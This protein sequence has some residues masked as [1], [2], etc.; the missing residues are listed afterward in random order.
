M[1]GIASQTIT[2]EEHSAEDSVGSSPRPKSIELRVTDTGILAMLATL[3]VVAT[4][5]LVFSRARFYIELA[6]QSLYLLMIE[7]P[8]AAIRSASGYHALL[9]PLFDAVGGSVV[10][11]RLLR[12]VLDIGVDI[13]LGFSLIRYL[14]RRHPDGKFDSTAAAG[15]V[16]ST[17]TLVGFSVWT[18]AVNGFGYDQLGGILFTVW[19]ALVLWLVTDDES[20]TNCALLA[21]AIGVVFTLG[22]IVR[23]TAS[24]AVALLFVWVLVERFG[25]RRARHLAG[26]VFLGAILGAVFVHFAIFDLDTLVGGIISG[27]VD[28]GRDSHSLPT[29]V[30]QYF[31]SLTT[32]IGGS[33]AIL[34]ASALSFFAL[35]NRERIRAA[36][37]AV[38]VLSG[39]MVFGAHAVLRVPTFI[40]ANSVGTVLALT[41]MIVW[42]AHARETISSTSDGAIQR[43]LGLTAT[44][45]AL[46]VLLAAG[47]FIPL[48]L[49]AMPLASLWVV[50]MWI[51]VPEL[52][53][54]RLQTAAAILS[55][56][57]I[58]AMPWLTWQGLQTPARTLP[59]DAPVEVERGRFEGLLVD[60]ATQQLL[61]DLED[62]RL[63]L[64]P[65]PTVLSF[66]ARPVVPFAL[67]GTGIGFPWYNNTRA[68]NAAA[69]T[70]SGACLDD[71]DTPQGDV[72]IVTEESDVR[73]FGT[74]Q[75]GLL[76]CGIDFPNGFELI[77]TTSTPLNT[78]LF[79]YLRDGDG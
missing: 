6:D 62:L 29:L 56:T 47:S 10:Q 7:N 23:W 60:A 44:L 65:N 40:G 68:P 15:A 14:R 39:L 49:T 69:V 26:H 2:E 21:T 30:G 48:F 16:V 27:T 52:G 8:R 71:G 42:L 78:E 18:F 43:N 31:V 67:E 64:D 9:A 46:P 70:L 11:F 74:I 76:D 55:I 51:V 57:I 1:V 63:Q 50:V 61:H 17:V 20:P 79:V 72:V 38:L 4:A 5:L 45:V 53:S 19:A 32:G 24:L 73:E 54:K 12:A 28:I 59:T 58:S 77:A 35:R 25:V 41:G 3:G 75:Q 13:G 33:I 22:A 37:P 66:W 36:M 34:L